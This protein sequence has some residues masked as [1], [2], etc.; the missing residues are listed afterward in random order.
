MCV[1]KVGYSQGRICWLC[2]HDDE[3]DDEWIEVM[4]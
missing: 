3:D 1:V 2:D 4:L